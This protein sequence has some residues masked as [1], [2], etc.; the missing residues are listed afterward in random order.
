MSF[1]VYLPPYAS[2]L[3]YI[4]PVYVSSYVRP[5]LC[6]SFFVLVFSYVSSSLCKSFPI[7][8][9]LCVCPS[10]CM[11]LPPLY[12]SFFFYKSFPIYIP[13]CVRPLPLYVPLRV[14]LSLFKFFPIYVPLCVH[15]SLCTS[16]PVYVLPCVSLFLYTSLPLYIF[17]VFI[18]FCIFVLSPC[19][20]LLHIYILL[21][22]C[23]I[24]LCTSSAKKQLSH[25]ASL[26][27]MR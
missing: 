21:Y 15:P 11:F 18:S 5:F 26:S 20:H 16:L 19:V 17:S 23:S 13:P 22:F 14:R 1:P 7:Y 27:R 4:P 3:M 24:S 9:P 10:L 12:T 25:M 2:L 6:T 8:V